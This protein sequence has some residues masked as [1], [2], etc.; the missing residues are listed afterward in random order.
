[1]AG[2]FRSVVWAASWALIGLLLLPSTA[3]A[4]KT[5][6]VSYE[7]EYRHYLELARKSP[8]PS[9]SDSWM[10]GLMLDTTARRANDLVTIRIIESVSATG[11]ADRTIGKAGGANVNAPWPWPFSWALPKILPFDTDSNFKGNGSTSRATAITATM[12]ARVAEV[13]SNGDL[14]I[15]GVRELEINGDRQLVVLS[16]VVRTVDISR[17]NVVLSSSVGQLSIRCLGKGK[18]EDGVTPGW[19]IRVLN[20]VF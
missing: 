19:L 1:M 12:T 4:Q 15:E 11:T 3:S 16:G 5:P 10:S 20:K 17:G 7:A 6:S 2:E 9:T 14:V 8:P 18:I 13:L